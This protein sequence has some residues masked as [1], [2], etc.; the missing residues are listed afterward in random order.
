MTS[1]DTG[2]AGAAAPSRW[3]VWAAYAVPVCV[4]PSAIWRV[5]L[6][7]TDEAPTTW[8]MIF[9][10]TLSLVLALSTLG[11]VHRWG[12]QVPRWVPLLGGRPIPPGP[13]VIL[14]AAGGALLVTISAYVV[15][16]LTFQVVPRG[17]VGVGRD[18]PAH[19]AP[20]W[21]V[22]RYYAPLIVWGPLVMA[23]AADH[24]RRVTSLRAPA[25]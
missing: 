7:F 19:P 24:R 14:A 4:L 22:L 18:E 13:V 23:V 8:Y 2:R 9:L 11:L 3:A 6:I 15:L 1:T 10:S 12:E 5:S 25:R 21:D 20:G 17:W 16:N